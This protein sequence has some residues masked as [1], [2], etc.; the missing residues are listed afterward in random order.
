M[1]CLFYSGT[2]LSN[3]SPFRSDFPSDYFPEYYVVFEYASAYC[4][5]RYEKLVEPVT[6]GFLIEHHKYQYFE[7]TSALL[8]SIH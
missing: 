6:S 3:K 7:S 8:L 5:P 4:Q 2:D 1:T